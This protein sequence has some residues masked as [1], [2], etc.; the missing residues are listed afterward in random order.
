V[1]GVWQFVSGR[2]G[3]TVMALLR[4]GSSRQPSVVVA[5]T[6]AGLHRSG[7]D[8]CS[9]STLSAGM[10]EPPIQVA[11][12]SPAFACDRTFLVGGRGGLARS[13]DGGRTWSMV[14][15]GDQVLA[16]AISPA[17]EQD[18][19]VLVGTESDGILRS[20]DAG[21]NWSS[22]N[23]GLLDLTV[24]AIGLSP[25]F[26]T[27]RI[28]FAGTASGLYR[29][30]SGGKAW[31][32]LDLP[33]E[34][35]AVQC[36]ALS[37]DYA[38]DRLVMAGTEAHGLLVSHDGGA[39]W[40]QVPSL[41]DQ[42]VAAVACSGPRL[43]AATAD[44]VM[45]SEDRGVSWRSIGRGLAGPVLTLLFVPEGGGATLLAGAARHGVWRLG[46][47]EIWRSASS[48]LYGR[49]LVGLAV[50][51]GFAHDHA[52]F[53][54][55]LDGG[56]AVSRDAGATWSAAPGDLADTP[57]FGIAVSPCYVEDRTL[58]AATAAGLFRSQDRAA[59]WQAVL[60]GSPVQVVAAG[61]GGCVLAAQPGG[62]LSA[63]EDHGT[64]WQR[65]ARPGTGEVVSLAW[66]PDGDTLFAGTV[67]EE[68][69]KTVVWRSA[70]RGQ[71]WQRWLVDAAAARVL[72][73][74]IL[75]DHARDAVVLVGVGERVLRPIR[76]TQERSR[77][78]RR[79]LWRAA[80]LGG[81]DDVVT[82][83]A[84]TGRLVLAGTSPGGVYR[85]W[86][87]GQTFAAWSD[88]LPEARGPVTALAIAADDVPGQPAFA[89]GLGSGVWRRHTAPD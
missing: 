11:A 34:A 56:V 71:S 27:D 15:T 37:P 78:E 45:L 16:A 28:G 67:G 12:V 79:P 68:G 55:E 43:A 20:E 35:P 51:P 8:A 59:T 52:L 53:L 2:A 33:V 63:S 44:G 72:P 14:L 84:T 19:L 77:G 13:T 21:R 50:S 9:W 81:R 42:G 40:E 75:P 7:D 57:A 22:G 89:L 31:R 88:G 66:A 58:F 85:S 24:L 64:T 36:L 76:G 18:Q 47:D 6:A 70:D 39:T 74:G 60:L 65:L 29:T 30:R 26:A 41:A 73:L 82:A 25:A 3:G 48:G 10:I 69:E 83:L 62:V 38:Q 1:P 46:K 32:V 49:L 5:A 87:A 86:D 54:A 17:F 80:A 4:P 61:T 23:P